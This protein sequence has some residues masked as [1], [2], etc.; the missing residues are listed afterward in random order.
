MLYSLKI[1]LNL[2]R[3]S[4]I[5]LLSLWNEVTQACECDQGWVLYFLKVV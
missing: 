1:N 5:F 2:S 4:S 3:I